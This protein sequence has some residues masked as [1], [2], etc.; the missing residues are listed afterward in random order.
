MTQTSGPEACKNALQGAATR[1][2]ES[3]SAHVPGV[4]WTELPAAT[5]CTVAPVP[6]KFKNES[7]DVCKAV[8]RPLLRRKNRM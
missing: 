4:R 6:V 8:G 2:L 1:A 7:S 5:E 3:V